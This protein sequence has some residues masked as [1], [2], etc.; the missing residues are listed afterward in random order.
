MKY[1]LIISSSVLLMACN[2]ELD[3]KKAESVERSEQ[4]EEIMAETNA[5]DNAERNLDEALSEMEQKLD[6]LDSSN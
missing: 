1:T 3:S 6:S 2:T 5:L 4:I